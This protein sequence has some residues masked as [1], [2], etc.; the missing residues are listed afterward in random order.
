MLAPEVMEMT[1]PETDSYDGVNCVALRGRVTSAPLER[2]LPS[3]DAIL[4][5]RLSVARDPQQRSKR[6]RQSA[7]WVDCVVWNGRTRRS[8]AGWQVGDQVELEGSLRRRFFR[9]ATQT[10]TRLEVEVLRGRRVAR[11]AAAGE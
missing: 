9:T 2:T 5:F 8:A 1:G 6:P 7:D 4:T 3:G 11:A 10:A